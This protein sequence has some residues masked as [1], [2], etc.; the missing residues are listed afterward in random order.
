MITLDSDNEK[1]AL[2]QARSDKSSLVY[3]ILIPYDRIIQPLQTQMHI[4]IVVY[5]GV[6][7]L[8]IF[9]IVF[10]TK[11]MYTPVRTVSGL[12]QNALDD[13]PLGDMNEMEIAQQALL[14]MYNEKRLRCRDKEFVA[15]LND[16]NIRWQG[17]GEENASAV[18]AVF[19]I[20][21]PSG[22]FI[23]ADTYREF[24]EFSLKNIPD[25]HC[26]SAVSF[27]PHKCICIL[28]KETFMD[29]GENRESS[30]VVLSQIRNLL[31]YTFGVKVCMGYS[32]MCGKTLK[33]AFSMA[34]AEAKHA[35]TLAEAEFEGEDREDDG[36][37]FSDVMQYVLKNY[38]SPEF[39]AKSLAGDMGMSLSN[40]SHYF[41]KNMGRTFSEYL[42]ALRLEKAKNLLET[43]DL[44]LS[45]IAERCGYLNGSAFMRSFKKQMGITPSVYRNEYRQ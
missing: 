28:L 13:M 44:T 35:E 3:A 38:G 9:A 18:L 12:A 26:I 7:I 23:D 24:A 33:E 32:V 6:I 2:Y 19:R 10:F 8:G 21:Y 20:V 37:T 15:A 4:T 25:G 41:K 43:T 11:R 14:I 31:E 36:R 39:S 29:S 1:Y 16:E 17:S 42:S 34:E 30:R 5:I 40:F 45:C 22:E 27:A